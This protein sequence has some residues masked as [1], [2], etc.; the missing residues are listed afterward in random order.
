MPITQT[1]SSTTTSRAPAISVLITGFGPFP[2]AQFNPT[3]KL[4]MALS[5]IR[6]PAFLGIRLV[7]HVFTTSYRAVDRDL[8]ELIRE[9]RPKVI[10]MFGLASRAPHPRVEI[11]ARNV[12]APHPD[13]SGFSPASR[14]IAK[15]HSLPLAI[16]APASRLLHAA[17]SRGIPLALSR[18]AGRYLCNYAY[19]RALDAAQDRTG[20]DLVAFIHVPMPRSATVPRARSR[21]RGP[22]FADL[23]ETGEAILLTLISATRNHH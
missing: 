20:P 18:D 1:S 19:W 15:G 6:R 7:A 21:R 8:Q 13:I 3:S 16:K 23:V 9:H 14:T 11:T 12:A 22:T 2:G 17:R 4:V 10:L 5:R